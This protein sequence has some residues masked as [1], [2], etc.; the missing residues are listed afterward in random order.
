MSQP[1]GAASWLAWARSL[2][3]ISQ[4]G[5]HFSRDV[6]DRE[7]Y[8]QIGAIAAEM[9]VN[10]TNLTPDQV[11]QLH[12]QEFGYATPKVDVRAALI[13]EGK[14]LLVQEALDQGRWTLPGG[15]ADVNE[16]PSQAV[17]RELVEE[18]G[19]RGRVVKLVGVWIARR[20]ATSPT[21][22]SPSTNC[23]FSANWRAARPG[24]ATK[25]ATAPS[26][27]PT[28][29]PP[30]YR[31]PASRPRNWCAAS[32]TPRTRRSPPSSTRGEAGALG[33]LSISHNRDRHVRRGKSCAALL[34]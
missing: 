27:P 26:L 25:P 29:C 14:V 9:L 34:C 2:Q 31:S 24:P 4:T 17:T 19:Y 7:R 23:A 8:T 28:R 18:T 32:P 20:R 12:A 13:H 3:A 22:P 11:L 6:F 33:L 30:T 10:Y 16:T 5:L 1:S 15:W 21:C